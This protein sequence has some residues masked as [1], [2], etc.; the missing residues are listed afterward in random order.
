MKKVFLF[1]ILLSNAYSAQIEWPKNNAVAYIAQKTMF[2]FKDVTVI[3]INSNIAFSKAT[4]NEGIILTMSIPIADF[5]SGDEDRDE[6]VREI[7]K[8]KKSKFLIFRSVK[9]S[10]KDY[11]QMLEGDPFY[12]DGLL[13]IGDKNFQVKF[14]SLREDQHMLFDFETTFSNFDIEPPSVA[15]GAVAKAKDYLVLKA[16]ININDF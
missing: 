15:F 2:F 3:G 9:M 16:K 5:K 4:L 13:A 12:V 8:V 14:R 11:Q 6:E 7:L 1:I 10:K